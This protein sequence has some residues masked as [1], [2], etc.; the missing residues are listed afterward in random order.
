L[1]SAFRFSINFCICLICKV[2][3]MNKKQ[4][5]PIHWQKLREPFS[6]PCRIIDAFSIL[7]LFIRQILTHCTGCLTVSNDDENFQF[8]LKILFIFSFY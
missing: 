1:Q 4:M 8:L 6:H 5:F 7:E 2:N 3:G